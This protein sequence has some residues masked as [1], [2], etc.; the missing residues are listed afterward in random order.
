VSD[1]GC[2]IPLN[3]IPY[4]FDRF[5]RGDQSREKGG[6]GL[7]LSIAK[8]IVTAHGGK[9]TASSDLGKGSVFTVVCEKKN[10]K[11]S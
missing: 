4:I 3:D 7:G 8:A 5:F 10:F 2:G 9:I 1:T 11:N 6:T